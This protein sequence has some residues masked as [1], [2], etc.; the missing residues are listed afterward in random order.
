MLFVAP[1]SAQAAG[2]TEPKCV[3]TGFLLLKKDCKA[4]DLYRNVSSTTARGDAVSVQKATLTV[5]AGLS[6]SA[7]YQLEYVARNTDRRNAKC[8]RKA[9]LSFISTNAKS[10]RLSGNFQKA[11]TAAGKGVKFLTKKSPTGMASQAVLKAGKKL[12]N[13]SDKAVTARQ[14][15]ALQKRTSD[16]MYDY[17]TR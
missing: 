4:R 5:G 8:V 3:R 11:F 16:C 17:Y 2:P 9:L 10:M 12:V 15:T 7:L 13:Q 6:K 1:I 14:L